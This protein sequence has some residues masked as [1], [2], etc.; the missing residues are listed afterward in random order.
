MRCSIVRRKGIGKIIILIKTE[1][2]RLRSWT[3]ITS[4]YIKRARDHGF[5]ALQRENEKKRRGKMA[6]S[7]TDPDRRVV[8]RDDATGASF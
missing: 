2:D 7:N 8:A 3:E 4:L 1:S 6:K 5:Q